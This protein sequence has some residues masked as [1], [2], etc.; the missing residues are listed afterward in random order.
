MTAQIA[1]GPDR[2][3]RDDLAVQVVHPLAMIGEASRGHVADAMGSG[4][5]DRASA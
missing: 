4:E 2:L 1:G 3:E 5:R